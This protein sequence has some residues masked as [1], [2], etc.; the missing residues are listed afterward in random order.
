ETPMRGREASAPATPKLPPPISV[1]GAESSTPRLAPTPMPAA[2]G[3]SPDRVQQVLLAV[4][5]DKTGYP[6][7]MLNPDMGLDADL[8]IDSIKRVEI[9]SAL[10]EHLPEA[11]T[12]KPEHLATLHTL[13][14]I[15]EFLCAPAV[16]SAASAAAPRAPPAA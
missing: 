16:E 7:E 1:A 8:G 4:V 14:Q 6:P 15:A 2:A 5:A 9:L 10:Q 12:V 13:G 3:L 11:P